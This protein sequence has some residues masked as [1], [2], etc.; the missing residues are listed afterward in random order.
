VKDATDLLHPLKVGDCEQ[1][2][3]MSVLTVPADPSL[4][5]CCCY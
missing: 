5:L 4:L 1:Q 2:R 3:N